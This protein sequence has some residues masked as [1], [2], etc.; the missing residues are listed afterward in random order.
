MD[1]ATAIIRS[2]VYMGKGSRVFVRED[3]KC[4]SYTLFADNVSIYDHN[5]VFKNSNIPISQQ[6][7]KS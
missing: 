7:Y 1:G 4:G 6:G 2:H 3:F 5:H